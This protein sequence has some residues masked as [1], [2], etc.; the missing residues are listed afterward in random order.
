[1]YNCNNNINMKRTPQNRGFMQIVVLAIVVIAV[2]AYFKIDLRSILGV[3]FANPE[4]QKIWHFLVAEFVKYIQPIIA[5]VISNVHITVDTA[6]STA[7]TTT[8]ILGN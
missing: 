8:S 2:L 3:I 7:A 5:Y 1:M 6:T 4:I